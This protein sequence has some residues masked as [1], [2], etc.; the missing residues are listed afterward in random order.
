VTDLGAIELPYFTH[1]KLVNW[2]DE[3]GTT[4][5]FEVKSE[6]RSKVHEKI[7]QIDSMWFKEKELFAF[8]EAEIRWEMNHIIG[9]LTCCVDYAIQE[10]VKPFFVLVF[11]ENEADHCKRLANTWEWLKRMLPAALK[12]KCLPI[13]TKRSEKRSGLHVS[14]ITQQA[15]CERIMRLF[16]AC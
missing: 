4:L 14:T 9:H 3:A 1:S 5:G 10:K 16:G 11:L 12:F 2:I 7:F 6:K 15:F 8:F 13:Y